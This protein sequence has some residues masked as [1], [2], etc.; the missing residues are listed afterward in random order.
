M[1]AGGAL[2]EEVV[3]RAFVLVFAVLVHPGVAAGEDPVRIESPGE[4]A[5]AAFDAAAGDAEAAYRETVVGVLRVFV[6]HLVDVE[7]ALVRAGRI[8]TANRV[9]RIADR[10]T[11]LA[12]EVSKHIWLGG[13]VPAPRKPE[14]ELGIGDAVAACREELAAAEKD[15]REDLAKARAEVGRRLEAP[16][17]LAIRCADLDGANRVKAVEEAV[18]RDVRDRLRPLSYLEYQFENMESLEGRFL[19]DSPSDWR[20]VDGELIGS[21][22]SGA[23]ITAAPGFRFISAVTLRARIVPPSRQNLRLAVGPMSAIFNWERAAQSHFRWYTDL[24]VVPRHVL[25]PGRE[26]DLVVRQLTKK[27]FEIRVDGQRVWIHHG[28]LLGTVS[29]YPALKST[30]GVRE[31]RILGVP[32]DR[33]RPDGP[34]H[35]H[36]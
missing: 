28:R 7:R 18:A 34:Y 11:A 5:S 23:N 6:G 35:R 27:S 36:R 16:L 32:E 30:I 10:N 33:P 26:Q 31:I 29:L 12:D 9:R 1:R 17:A 15:Y 21:A 13:L 8:E 25:V 2:V 24:T 14:S 20:I 3:M 22:M 4:M 19:V